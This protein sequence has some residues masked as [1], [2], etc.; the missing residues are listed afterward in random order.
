[1][2]GPTKISRTIESFFLKSSLTSLI[3]NSPDK[4]GTLEEFGSKFVVD[5]K[6]QDAV[7]H[8]VLEKATLL[9]PDRAASQANVAESAKYDIGKLRKRVKQLT[10][11]ER[12]TYL[13]ERWVPERRDEY[14]FSEKRSV[15]IS[16]HLENP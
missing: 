10:D 3:G 5:T 9:G 6:C 7:A 13:L 1:M 14:P 4:S 2:S 8:D 11:K 16:R 12:Q 15:N